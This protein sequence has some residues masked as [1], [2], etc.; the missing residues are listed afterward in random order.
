[1]F[2]SV[3]QNL[4]PIQRFGT[5]SALALVTASCASYAHDDPYSRNNVQYQPSSSYA[6]PYSNNYVGEPVRYNSTRGIDAAREAHRDNTAYRAEQL[7]GDCESIVLINYGETISDIA[8]FCDVS[9]ASILISNPQIRNP[10]RVSVGDQV[11]IPSGRANVYADG[12]TGDR[13][14]DIHYQR[15]NRQEGARDGNRGYYVV[16]AGDTL[17]EIAQHYQVSLN[18]IAKLNPNIQPR[19]LAIGERVYLPEYAN[20]DSKRPGPRHENA[21]YNISSPVISI[22]PAHGPRNGEIRLIGDNFQRDEQVYIMY[23]ESADTLIRIRTIES[24]GNGRIDERI[25]LPDS[26]GRDLAYFA[27]Q[28]GSDTYMSQ[29]YSVDR[30]SFQNDGHSNG[31]IFNSGGGE[32]KHYSGPYASNDQASLIAIDQDVYWGDKVTLVAHSFP[33]NTPVS[34]YVGPNRNALI[35]IAE[36]RTGAE[37]VFQTQVSIPDNM[38]SDSVYFVAAVEDGART[39]FS[40]RVRIRNDSDRRGGRQHSSDDYIPSSA[41]QT[42]I[43]Y[44]PSTMAS[45]SSDS[46]DRGREN[47]TGNFGFMS[48]GG[49]NNRRDNVNINTGGESAVSGI[50]T[51]EGVSCPTLRDDAGR[52]YTLL[53]DLQGFDDG[54]RVLI[55]GSAAADRRICGQSETIQVFSIA[56]APW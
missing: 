48:R 29:S 34:I 32:N 42:Q 53:G 4:K 46:L 27:I 11:R 26:Y 22:T 49:Q 20:Y 33:P 39:Y 21:P 52:L 15:N 14:D 28:H 1:M 41:E 43:P 55:S 40:E 23:G 12:Q 24:D 51:N 2:T 3:I 47:K 31:G 5:V 54:D 7:D 19:R 8:E 18:D 35:K 10:N 38:N 45:P 6:V 30:A 9:V 56:K 37:G 16:R 17:A 50:L 44:R 13:F 36:T 25:N